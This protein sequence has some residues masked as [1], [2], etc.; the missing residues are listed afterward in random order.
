[1]K[2]NVPCYNIQMQFSDL[3]SQ[4]GLIAA[5]RGNRSSAPEN[6]LRAFSKSIGMCDFIELDVQL[7]HD[8]VVVVMHDD[9][10]E[11]TTDISQRVEFA[12]RKP[13]YVMELTLSEL[14][15]LDAGSWFSRKDPFGETAKGCAGAY[16]AVPERI[17]TLEETLRFAR[18]NDL[19][20]NVEIK[21]MQGYYDDGT[22]VEKVLDAIDAQGCGKRVLL[23]SFCHEYMRIAKQCKPC[24]QASVL[25]EGEPPEQLVDYLRELGVDGYHCDD[26]SVSKTLVQTL[27]KAGFFVG[28]YTVNDAERRC[29]LFEWGVNAVFTD[30]PG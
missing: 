22:V 21:E 4:T 25:Q 29:E 30:F 28:V 5:H 3:I 18:E 19:L 8:G 16:D 11:R 9:T 6:T 2:L 20:L 1:M 26:A 24:I 27:R 23:S 14:K 10:L 12:S 13:W 15:S 7:S 17:P